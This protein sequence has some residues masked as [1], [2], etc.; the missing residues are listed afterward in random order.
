MQA[1]PV[2]LGVELG[3]TKIVVASSSDGA[4]IDGRVQ[5]RTEDPVETLKAVRAALDELAA[6]RSVRGVGIAS[7]GPIDLR[8]SSEQFGTIIKTPKPGWSGVDVVNG[9]VP[10]G[11][12]ARVDTDVA[13]ALI[14]EHRWGAARGDT[15]AYFTVGT[16]IGAAVVGERGVV[17]GANHSEIGHI[18]VPRHPDDAFPG[19]CPYHRDC[20]EGMA[21]GPA[22][23]DRFGVPADA[24]DDDQRKK[25]VDLVAWYL[26][27]GIAA[28]ACV[29][30]VETV[31]IGGG[32]AKLPGV[33]AATAERLS[34]IAAGY[35][36]VPFAEGGP[37]VVPPAFGDDA[38]VLGAIVLARQAGGVG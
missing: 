14:A 9:I 10:E 22:I 23:H 4:D 33:H 17:S 21:C 19:R 30:P 35:P 13:A 28:M 7:F 3:G 16:G 2:D 29:V 6:E 5:L 11:V 38:G 31:V 32:V 25:A 36:P 18:R 12:P 20:L 15:A 34:E 27:Q 24:L 37:S 26:A 8:R 1:P